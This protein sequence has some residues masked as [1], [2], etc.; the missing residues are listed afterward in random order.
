MMRINWLIHDDNDDDYQKGDDN[1]DDDGD[2]DV[3]AN[4]HLEIWL[5]RERD[6]SK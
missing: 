4:Q 3:L 1:D 2:S 5:E 6:N